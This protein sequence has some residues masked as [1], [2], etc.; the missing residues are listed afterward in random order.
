MKNN[1]HQLFFV[2]RIDYF[3]PYFW[4]QWKIGR[5]R[6]RDSSRLKMEWIRH[7]SVEICYS[8]CRYIYKRVHSAGIVLLIEQ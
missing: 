8:Q 7:N 2:P 5:K 1:N 4:Q 3:L 6:V